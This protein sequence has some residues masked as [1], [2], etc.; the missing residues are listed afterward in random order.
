MAHSQSPLR[1]QQAAM[2]PLHWVQMEIHLL[3]MACLVR[4]LSLLETT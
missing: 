4:A 3:L 2:D 1:L